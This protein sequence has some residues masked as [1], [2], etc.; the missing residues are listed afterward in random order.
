LNICVPA[1]RFKER[2]RELTMYVVRLGRPYNF[3]ILIEAY[4]YTRRESFIHDD[5]KI[6]Y[7]ALLAKLEE[8]FGIQISFEKLS[9]EKKPLWMLFQSTIYSLLSIRTPWSGF[10]DET[11]VVSR[12]KECGEYEESIYQFSKLIMQAAHTSEEAHHQMLYALFKCIFG[13]VNTVITSEQLLIAGF[14]DSKEP[15]IA[16]YFDYM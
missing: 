1:E 11:L 6:Y 9:P 10:L 2:A 7:S 15:D 4:V 16:D 5:F 14:D 3:K 12:L 13:D 8:L